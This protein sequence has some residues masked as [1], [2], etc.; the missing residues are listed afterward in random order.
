MKRKTGAVL[1]LLILFLPMT[2]NATETTKVYSSEEVMALE[3]E[4]WDIS[5]Y[6]QGSNYP[7]WTSEKYGGMP[8]VNKPA[9]I[10]FNIVYHLYRYVEDTKE[11]I[12]IEG[13]CEGE[14]VYL[15]IYK[16]GV[17]VDDYFVV[18]DSNGTAEFTV[19]F[20]EPGYY[21]YESYTVWQIN[22]MGTRTSTEFYV[23]PTS[24]PTSTP[25]QTV[26]PT[27]SPALMDSDNDGVPDKY[28]YAPYD[29]KVQTKSDIKTP[30]F[31]VMFAITGLLV[32]TYLLKR[33]K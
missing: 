1:V 28:D 11:D 22:H 10:T 20:K 7:W 3:K 13:P 23:E 5:I 32:V 6:N 15:D 21:R 4:G 31:E 25:P 8:T 2:A 14:L 33:R 24:V 19:I 29:P 26:V 12:N 30:G 16:G 18:S 17:L 27:V 9:E